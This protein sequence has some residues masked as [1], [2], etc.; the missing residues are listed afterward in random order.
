MMTASQYFGSAIRVAGRSVMNR[1]ERGAIREEQTVFLL[2]HCRQQRSR[3]DTTI[4]IS[5][6]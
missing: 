4:G 3:E 6:S 2:H 1:S 5:Y